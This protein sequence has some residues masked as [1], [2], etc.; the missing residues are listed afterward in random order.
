LSGSH[1]YSTTMRT[2]VSGAYLALTPR[3]RSRGASTHRS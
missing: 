1:M 2:V 3:F